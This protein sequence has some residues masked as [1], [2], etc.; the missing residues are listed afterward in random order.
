MSAIFGILEQV[1]IFLAGI[2]IR[3][4]VE[5]EDLMLEIT[6]NGCGIH[7]DDMNKPKSFGLRSIRERMRGLGGSLE[8]ARHS[9]QGAR[10]ILRAPYKPIE[11]VRPDPP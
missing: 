11:T 1:G 6:D 8:L 4:G 2:G 10:V 3:L 5:G 7:A 9:P